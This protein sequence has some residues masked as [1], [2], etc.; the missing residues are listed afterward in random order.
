MVVNKLNL[1]LNEPFIRQAYAKQGDTGRVFNI[2]IDPTPTENG[3]LR[4]K[5]P[6]GVEVTADAL[7][8]ADIEPTE[9]TDLVTF[10]ALEEVPLTKLEVGLSSS[11]DLH[12][13]SNPYPSGGGVNKFDP[14]V[15]AY[16]TTNGITFSRDGDDIVINNTA[17][18]TAYLNFSGLSISTTE[19]YVRFIIKASSANSSVTLHI[20]PS[21]GSVLNLNL[22]SAEVSGAIP[23]SSGMTFSGYLQVAN[24]ASFTNFHLS[25]CAIPYSSGMP[26]FA[27]YSNICPI[28]PSNGVNLLQN[29]ASTTSVQGCDFTVNADG[30]VTVNGKSTGWTGLTIGTV[31]L[32]KGTYVLSSGVG[33]AY[34]YNLYLSASGDASGSTSAGTAQTDITLE[35]DGTVTIKLYARPNIQQ[36]NNIKVY[37]MLR[38][39]DSSAPF[40]VP[41]QGINLE[42]RGVN[43]WD[44]TWE[45]GYYQASN[46]AK[47][48][49]TNYFRCSNR[50]PVLPNT[51][52]YWS[53]VEALEVFEWAKDGSYLRRRGNNY[54][55][56]ALTTSEDCYFV[57]FNT[58]NVATSY[59]NDISINYPSTDHDYHAYNGTTHS[60]S[61]GRSVYGGKV[62]LVSGKLVVDKVEVDMGTL[63]WNRSASWLGGPVLYTTGLTSVITIPQASEVS[64]ALCSAYQTVSRATVDNNLTIKALAV[65]TDGLVVVRDS[66]YSD[67][68]T[69]QSAMSGQQLVYP[70]ATPIEYDLTPQQISTLLGTNNIFGQTI[71]EVAFEYD[72][73]LAELPSEATEV[74]GRCIGDVEL[75]GVSTMP[76]T[77]V[78]QKNNQA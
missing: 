41:Y 43:M 40:Y 11:Q 36:P 17:T 16:R 2:E 29:T 3:T 46:G 61:L 13:Q 53:T 69:F 63:T 55:N 38:A 20:E 58:H 28:V 9:P 44:E 76:F 45:T 22:S 54:K 59:N 27:P 37:P 57:T 42:Q 50:I 6:D 25:V 4:I 71:R 66:N 78:V 67:G 47:V 26:T 12:G 15:F 72:G 10:T 18:A 49:S 35:S 77:L 1:S 51:S 31:T 19:S 39:K 30:T 65:N 14:S 34:S 75:N 5:R 64:S 23:Y 73:V 74:A 24:G 60:I 48:A 68:A 8:S 70:L 7:K 62:D 21:V 33:I 52:Y 32:P 56:I